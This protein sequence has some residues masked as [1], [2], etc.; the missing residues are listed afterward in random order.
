MALPRHPLFS[1]PVQPTFTVISPN[2]LTTG[3]P[4]R[5]LTR[6]ILMSTPVPLRSVQPRKYRAAL[7]AVHGR[8]IR[9]GV[10]RRR[11]MSMLILHTRECLGAVI[12]GVSFSTQVFTRTCATGT[13]ATSAIHWASLWPPAGCRRCGSWYGCRCGCGCGC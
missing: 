1:L 13:G 8:P 4:I 7:W 10:T 12:A 11:G 2:L 9:T 6:G 3:H 5:R